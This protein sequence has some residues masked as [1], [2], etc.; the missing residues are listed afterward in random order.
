[1][2]KIITS[3]S[4]KEEIAE[5]FKSKFKISEQSCNSII[6]EDISGDILLSLSDKEF[7]TLDLKIGP[8][9]KITKYLS[10]NKAYFP[11]KEINENLDINSS[12][13]EVK[14]F[15][16]EFIGYTGDKKFDGKKLLEIDK[17]NMLKMGLNL[18]QR[19]RLEK[20]INYFK[21]TTKEK[22]VSKNEDRKEQKD[23]REETQSP[24]EIKNTEI[25]E[26]LNKNGKQKIDN[27]FSDPKK[28]EENKNNL[29]DKKEKKESYEQQ[30]S[31]E[32]EKSNENKEMNEKKEGK[33]NGKQIAYK[34]ENEA[35]ADKGEDKVQIKKEENKLI[36]KEE[37]EKKK[38]KEED[39]KLNEGQI[40][41]EKDNI[42]K[43]KEKIEVQIGKD[44]GKQLNKKEENEIKE[45]KEQDK[46]IT[47]K[48][49]KETKEQNEDKE[50][51][52]EK[53]NPN[54]NKK[55]EK[56][57]KENKEIKRE[58]EDEEVNGKKD[59]KEAKEINESKKKEGA[60]LDKDS[61][62]S[63]H[64]IAKESNKEK[65]KEQTFEIKE[66]IVKEEN[67]KKE[68]EKDKKESLESENKSNKQNKKKKKKQKQEKSI[69]SNL[70]PD[71]LKIK[72][73]EEDNESEEENDNKKLEQ[74]EKPPT[75]NYTNI[76]S[77]EVKPLDI[78]SKS[79][80]FFI[81]SLSEDYYLNSNLA[82]YEEDEKKKY[83]NYSHII[84]S[85]KKISS[86]DK[87]KKRIILVQV[88]LEKKI[89][90]LYIKFLLK[91][92]NINEN[93]NDKKEENKGKEENIDKEQ[94]KNKEENK[95]KEQNKE[96][97]QNKV[98]EQNKEDSKDNFLK[99]FKCQIEVNGEMN[100]YFYL[101]NLNFD[102]KEDIFFDEN[103]DYLLGEYYNYFFDKKNNDKEIYKKEL[104]QSLITFISSIKLRLFFSSNNLFKFFKLCILYEYKI[105]NINL[106]ELF[107][108]SD[109]YKHSIDEENILNGEE[110]DKLLLLFEGKELDIA[111]QKLSSIFVKLYSNFNRYKL[112]KD[113]INSKNG[114]IYMRN[115]FKLILQD[116]IKISDLDIK[117][118]R[119][120][121]TLKKG[122]LEVAKSKDEI[123]YINKFSKGL[124]GYLEFINENCNLICN[125]LE[126]NEKQKQSKEANYILNIPFPDKEDKI[127][128][129]YELLLVILKIT[130]NKKYSILKY[131]ELFNQLVDIAANESIDELCLLKKFI[132]PLKNYFKKDTIE[133]YYNRIHQKG[134][135]LIKNEELGIGEILNF[136]YNQDIYYYDD[137]YKDSEN[138]DPGIFSYTPIRNTEIDN[139][140]NIIYL[141]ERKIWEL[142]SKSQK[143]KIIKF[144]EVFLEQ[145][146][147]IKDLIPL[148]KLFP[149]SEI[150]L[151]F[152]NLINKKVVNILYTCLDED[153]KI[154]SNSKELF[155]IFEQLLIYNNQNNLDVIA[156]I[157]LVK[158]N[159]PYDFTSNYFFYLLQSKNVQ[160]IIPKIKNNII[161]YFIEQ[162]KL[163]NTTIDSLIFL[164]KVAPDDN[165]RIEL[166]NQM[167][168]FIM[169]ENDFYQKSENKKFIL[170]KLFNE[171]FP[172]LI[173]KN[174]NKNGKYLIET[175]NLKNK[176]FKD[177]NSG[178]VIYEII[179][180][181]LENENSFYNKIKVLT[182]FNDKEAKKLLDKIK[183]FV[184]QSQAK[185][186]I[187]DTI[188]DYYNTFYNESKREIIQIIKDNIKIVKQK[189]IKKVLDLDINKFV[190]NENFNLN[191]CKEDAENI[192]YKYSLFFMPIYREKYSNEHLEKTE[193][194]IFN[195]TIIILKDI[196][197]RI[198]NQK[199]T[200]EPFFEINYVEIILRIIQ[201]KNNNINNE[202]NFISQELKDLN[203]DDYIKNNLLADLINFSYKNSLVTLLQGILY[204]IDTFNKIKE[205]QTTDIYNNIQNIYN[206]VTQNNVTAD[207]IKESIDFLIKYGYNIK[208]EKTSLM[209]FYELLLD[210]EDAITFIKKIKE[211]QL[212]I[213]NLNEFIDEQD[214]SQ[215]TT[216]DIDNLLDIYNFINGI[217]ENQNITRDFELIE[218]FKK[219]FNE[220]KNIVIK[221]KEYLKCYGEIIQ[222]YKLY[223]ENPEVTT[224]KVNKIL[225]NSSVSFFKDEKTNLYTFK[226]IYSNQNNINKD[227]DISEL[228]EL[229]YR[230]YMSSTGTN[231]LTEENKGREDIVNKEAM[232]NKFVALIDNLN[233]LNKTLNRLIKSGYPFISN[234]SLKIENSETFD[235]KDKSKNLPK[236]IEEHKSE[237]KKF[238]KIIKRG[239]QTKPL[240]RLFYAYQFIQIYE[241]IILPISKKV[242]ENN[243]PII[244][245]SKYIMNL[246]NYMMQNQIY[247]FD[248]D[249][250]YK[251]DLDVIA[252]INNYLELLLKKNDLSL[253]KIYGSN[254]LLENIELTPGL[255]RK[256]KEGDYS[257]LSVDIINIYLN[258]TGNFPIV[259]T[260]L[261]C[262]EETTIEE[263]KAFLY[264]AIYCEKPILF[265][266]T[267][268]ECLG[269]S[270]TQNILKTIRKLYK[271]KNRNINSYLVFIYEKIDSGFSRF[272]EKLIPE[273]NILNKNFLKK[274]E[275]R[276]ENLDKTVVYSSI[277]SG[278]GK[279][280]EIYYHVKDKSG[281]YYYLPLGGTFTRD[282]VIK[283]LKNLKLDTQNC[284]YIY[285]HLDLSDT[286]KDEL[287]NEILFKLVILRYL[288][289]NEEIF[290]LGY[291]INII[292]EI[293]QGFFDFEKK[294]KILTLFKKEFIDKLRP[295]R[296][297]ENARFL[298]ES[299]ISIVAEVLTYYEEDKIGKR[300]IDLDDP[301][302]MSAEECELIINKYFNVE[303]Q[304]YY[305]KINFIKILSLQFKKLSTNF[306]LDYQMAFINGI[307][308]LIKKAR[309]SII[310]N[311][312][313]L[314]KVFTR[315][316][317]DQLLIK[318]Q[319]ESID[320]YNRYDQNLAIEK[321]ISA[322]ENEKQ[323][324]FSFDD[325]KPSL[326]FFNK[327]GQSFGII[328]N[329]DKNDEEYKELETLWNSN[330]PD[331]RRRIPLI[332]YKSMSHDK[333]LE[334]IQKVFSLDSFNIPKLKEICVKAGNYIFVCDN[335]IKMVRILLN[336]E[337]KIPVILMGE[338][339]V[340]KTKI[341]EMLAT[342]YGKGRL[343]WKKKEI[344][345][346]TTDEEIVAFIDKIIEEDKIENPD[347]DLT[348]VFFDEINTCNSLGLITEIM[349]KHTYLG[350]KISDNLV[351]LGACNPY[352]VLN[353]KMRESGL[354]YYNT[355]DKSK[356]NNLV[357]S[358][359]PLPHSLLNF[360]FDFGSLRKKDEEKY[361]HN[362]IVS[363]IDNIKNNDLI[364]NISDE[365]LGKLIEII[366]DSI[367][368]CHDFIREKYDRS[369]V[370]MREIRRFGIFF[371]YFIKYFSMGHFSDLKR[372]SLSLNMTIYLCYYLR[373]NDKM[374]R[375]ELAQKLNKYYPKSSF[376]SVPENEIKKITKEMVIE[377][378]KG[379]ALNRALREN[380][381]TCFTCIINNVPLII[382]GKPGTGKSLS[383]QILYNSMK[384]EYSESKLFKD[385]GKLYRYYYQGSETSTAEGITQVFMKALS[386]Q[387]NNKDKKIIPLVFFDEMGLAE[388]SSNNPL[389]VIHFL[390]EKDAKD[391]VPFLGISNW[392]LDAAK[393]NRALGLTITDYDIQ[394]LEE[395][396]IS[397]A[398]AMD[399]RLTSLY[400]DFFKTLA[401]TYNKYILQNQK[402]AKDNKDFHGNRDFYNLI[403]NAMRE[404]IA[405]RN[406][407]KH[408]ER[409]ILTEVGILSLERNFGGLEDSTKKVKEI[410]K[411]EF[412][413]KFDESVKID[414][415]IDIF[416]I[417][418]KNI[419]DQNSRYLML[420]S[421]GNDA[422][423]ILKCL[424]SNINKRYIE[425]VGSKY[426]LDIKSGRYSEEILN[427]IKYIMET[428]DILILKDLDMIYP[429][430][431]DLF[432][433]N[434]TIM[435]NK[436]FARIAFEYAKISSEVNRNFHVVVLVN[437]IQIQNLKLDPPFL[438]RFEK[439]IVS[440]RML[441]DDEDISIG[442]KIY[443]Y[444]KLIVTY[445][446]NKKL[447]LDLEKLL[448]NCKQHDIEGL[449]FK[450]KTDNPAILKD[451]GTKD[452]ENYI[453]NEIFKKI[454]P[455]F[456]QDII[457]SIKYSN[458]NIKYSQYNE[459]IY[460]IY[461]KTQ[462]SNFTSFF[463]NI[464][465]R[466]NI[467]YTF[468]K[469]TENIFEEKKIIE[470]KFGTYSKQSAIDE[471][472]DSFK[473]ENDL[474]FLLK[475][476]SNSQKLNILILRFGEND[477]N[478]LNSVNYL[479]NTY[480]KE[481]K[482]LQ[483]KQIMFI[484]H[485]KR[486]TILDQKSKN[487]AK[488]NKKLVIPDLIPF[489]NDEYY[490]IFID[491]LQGNEGMDLFKVISQQTEQLTQQYL[492]ESNLI[493]NKIYEV[494]NYINFEV[495]F[496][497]KEINNNNYINVIAKKIIDNI[498]IKELLKKNIEKQGKILGGVINE[499]YT[500]DILE[501]N[502]IDFFEV[503]NSKLSIYLS[504]CLL[505]VIFSG[506]KENLFNQIVI[507]DN[508]DLFMKNEY[509]KNLIKSY[510]DNVDFNFKIKT[511]VNLNKI[512]IYNGLQIP[513]S[514][515]YLDKIVKYVDDEI[516]NRFI[517]NED[518][519]RKN[520]ES[521]E[522]ISDLTTNYINEL[523]QFENNI[524]VE[525]NNYELFK[526]IYN[527]NN[528]EIKRKMRE[529]YLIYYVIKII[530]K[531]NTNYSI[532]ENILEILYLLLKIKFCERGALNRFD[533]VN[534]IEE[535]AKIILFTQGYKEDIIDIINI[536]L[537]IKN[538]CNI[539]KYM[540]D[541][542]EE[543]IIKYEDSERNQKYT[544]KVNY[545]F[546][547]I[548]ESLIRG[549]LLY[550]IELKKNDQFKFYEFFFTLPSIEANLQKINQKY[551]LYSKQIYNLSS[552]IKIHEC[553]KFNLEE[554]ENK[555]EE[556]VNNL[557]NQS[558]LLY[559]GSYENLYKKI[560][561]LHKIF[562]DTFKDKNNEFTNLLF[563]ITRQEYQ[564]INNESIKIKLIENIFENS[565][566]IKKSYTFL[567][568]TMKDLKPEIF[569]K[570]DKER[571]NEDIL[572]RN[573]LN[574]KDNR[575]LFKY[576]DLYKLF[577]SL[578]SPEFNELLLFF[579]ENQ[580]QSYF[581]NILNLYNNKFVENCC[582]ALLLNTS[583]DYLK[584]SL[585][586]IYEHKDN[587]DNNI[588]KMYSI[589]YIKTYFYYY[590]EI[591]YNHF[592]K[593]NYT[594]INLLLMDNN[595]NI[596]Y[597]INMRN[598]Y[599]FR[600][601]FKKFDNF[602][603][604]KNF[605]FDTRNMPLYKNLAETIKL[606]EKD[607]DNYIF[608]D[609][610][611]NL[612]NFDKYKNFIQII[613]LFLL[614][615]NSKSVDFNFNEVN[616]NF[617]VFFCCLV[618]KMISYLYGNNKNLIEEKMKYLYESTKD[619]IYMGEEGKILYQYLFNTN[620]LENN[621]FKKI[622]DDKLNQEDFEILLYVLRIIFNTQMNKSNNFYNNILKANTCKFIAD[623]YIP[624]SFPYMNEYIKSYNFLLT[625]FPPKELMGYYICKDCG[626]V[627]EIRPC[628]FPVHTYQCPNGHTIGGTNHILSKKDLRIFYD[629][630]DLNGFC[631]GR[632]QSYI[633]SFNGMTLA[634]FKKNYVDKHL[635][636]KEKGILENFE[637]DDFKKNDPVRELNNLTYRFLNLI[638]YS[639]LL[640]SYILQNLSIE[641]MRK[642]LVDNLFP[643][644]LFG[645]IK[646]DWEI[647]NAAL[648]EIGFENINI[649]MNTKFNE[650]LNL[651]NNLETVD[652]SEK[653]DKFEKSVDK[654]I[655]DI[656]NNKDNNEQLNNEYKQLN[657]KLLNFNPQSIKEIIQS[658]Y[659]PSIY[660][661]VTYP[662]IQ[663]Y[664]VSKIIN[665]ETFIEKFNSSEENKNKYA[666][667]NIL[668][669][670][671]SELTKNA[672]NMKSLFAINKLV[673]LLL[674]IYSYKI[675]RE[676]SKLK[677]LDEEIPNIIS[678]YN[679]MNTIKINDNESFISEYISPFIQSWNEIKS[680]SVQYKCRVLRDLEKGEKPYEM[681][682]DNLL[683]DFLVDD[684]DKEGGMFLAAA[685][686]YLIESQ[687]TFIDNIISKN[688]IKGILNSYVSQ[689]EQK[690][691]IQDASK[692]EI[693]NIDDN[694]Y[695]LLETLVT[696]NSLRNIFDDKKNEIDYSNYNDIIYNYD[697]IEE[698]LGKKIL[699]GLKKFNN[700][701][702]RF[703]TFL[704][705]GFRGEHSS[706][707]VNYNNKYLQRDLKENEKEALND[708]LETNNSSKFYNDVFSSLQIL[709]NQII[710]E[711]YSQNHLLYSI[712][713]NLPSY[714]ILNSKLVDFFKK[715]Y[716]YYSELQIFTVNS[717][718]SIFEYFESLCWK[719]M[720]KNI[721][722]DY[723]QEL[724]E[725]EKNDFISYFE[726]NNKEEKVINKE[727]FTSALR[728][729]ICRS[730]SGSRQE[731][732]IK[733]DGKLLYYI[734]RE[735]LWNK[736][737][738]EKEE[739]DNEVYEIFKNEILVSQAVNLY[740]VL[741]GDNILQDKLFKNKEKE[742]EN[743][744]Q[745]ENIAYIKD[746]KEEGDNIINTDSS[747]MKNED[748]NEEN[749]EKED[750][751]ASQKS[752]R[753][754]D[755]DSEEDDE[756][757]DE[758][759]ERVDEI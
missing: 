470:N 500:S 105:K 178:Q 24:I 310:K 739:F 475:S 742:K 579:F 756:D 287:M 37:K 35:Q 79:N 693:I 698:E 753:D 578:N 255:Y 155:E 520:Y 324:I 387:S 175:I 154:K 129:I 473:C 565:L 436:Q 206:K 332:D 741:E 63:S 661:Q 28:K 710:K 509:F 122:F 339:G 668:I 92:E 623:N 627:Y 373:L 115:I 32:K 385:K 521:Q 523:K 146:M 441:L 584:K 457:A 352:R 671:D 236:I 708:L 420:I 598:I 744:K 477:L 384:G 262:N 64:D 238:K 214:N 701:K 231:L 285:L 712:I 240:L 488:K 580:C 223:D 612:N 426:K 432:N 570:N 201:N 380:L 42:L 83:I 648:K 95:D 430:L 636:H 294:Y 265:V 704:Y 425:L 57:I 658:N 202:I 365:D 156:S 412:K 422:G 224:Q 326:V 9:K 108:E 395:T 427:K 157:D 438:N 667:I 534:D 50:Q 170:F 216:T 282:Y 248:I 568:D 7:K 511:G 392:K 496:E 227:I 325:I 639:Y 279:T 147:D 591:N 291:D 725:N 556:I 442:Q 465:Q 274:P 757:S 654:F 613:N 54:E 137:T 65:A 21:S 215:L 13:E 402:E 203:K 121:K 524:L 383:F 494:L 672:K 261:F 705:E 4:S 592:D 244:E 360:V 8:I 596:K 599:I 567:V 601:Y 685:Y 455:T 23:N 263:I 94:N 533:F 283:N 162:H 583:L 318:R 734:T 252:N 128:K 616:E 604:F 161:N 78:N 564:N 447:K 449:I 729:L 727:N 163:G 49:N 594:D 125:I 302:S 347:K 541:I 213:R 707:L 3:N 60:N 669:N 650:I 97:E 188:I 531:K 382:V 519:L 270:V 423:E 173:K 225:K 196:F 327:D 101:E 320:I 141:K 516:C 605:P 342:L 525:I 478:K 179:E 343:N 45:D 394:D 288:D 195:S 536:I 461:K 159:L 217:M 716:E 440:F 303:N 29:E 328:S 336:I 566:L 48:K 177:L 243:S 112:L 719:E 747:K 253:D 300:N 289:S 218:A 292:I 172:D 19:K 665:M 593:C 548:I 732:E 398:E 239:Y 82:T 535:F 290:Y 416:D 694:I 718:V 276:H 401:R 381:F 745:I 313:A 38:D 322:L 527:Q 180:N 649:F 514:K 522:E 638:L 143:N 493:D 502:D 61:N 464:Q 103:N 272:L 62:E 304:N 666:L 245:P 362:T 136:I 75:I 257:D 191:Q 309:I 307:G 503:I 576:K 546:F 409:T 393:I 607:N 486:E 242:D 711:N 450:I 460:N 413:H 106:I 651:I 510:F 467:V 677:K 549:I 364:K 355:K 59:P 250:K 695:D 553:Y 15:L 726:K 176:I 550:S 573:F 653:L 185:F 515:T 142:F 12:A 356:L 508:Y 27:E 219:T 407:I 126:K 645:I 714:I 490:Q 133:K 330:N 132:E 501:V 256:I 160:K 643:H 670:K 145:I 484:I 149:S 321:A 499:I 642:Y 181:L 286:D 259:N 586:Y 89:K 689:L 30:G 680:K 456:C 131:D 663:Y 418:K 690:I 746:K 167:D 378:N 471:M 36:N 406:N 717:L 84:L 547:K 361:I 70:I 134:M 445:N 472:I 532:N 301:I 22:K 628:T 135:N 619:K 575:K 590:V 40:D 151:D 317:Y 371:E 338:T 346:G 491:N 228:N 631:N 749:I 5:F 306:Y 626:Y 641:E 574:I 684:G 39:K 664:N 397:I 166:L 469:I 299:P 448:I 73:D 246:I 386:S 720:K 686:Q 150:N 674:A 375:R 620:L 545:Y 198:I 247:D 99:E 526:E 164:I 266:I 44:K 55:E 273:K 232:T 405:R 120:M 700:D 482:K 335:F 577:N 539:G 481:N 506:L 676:D 235:E 211:S 629:Q 479:I 208:E 588:L 730:I 96:K 498:Q 608:K 414:R 652:T 357:Y 743:Q 100:N 634:D 267:N 367:V 369:S 513:K 124:I 489:I 691:N 487:K 518:S 431:Y 544:K 183:D 443:D 230:I 119:E 562:D 673:N 625:K 331:T 415:K 722:P 6:K 264:R 633:N 675:S 713:E 193:D 184:K 589:A 314:T 428:D 617:D 561:D 463:R 569:D 297:E 233:Q 682:I 182:D 16:K 476:F 454:V 485:K 14:N 687:N 603:Q 190:E 31:N 581:K 618:N 144:Y 20:Y 293:P 17:E 353:K 268:L 505:K 466:R 340:G 458:M 659:P 171:K 552:I 10:E 80:I 88:P 226:I 123:N 194:D 77:N 630:N 507:S 754:N 610:F 459:L 204:F 351:F 148:F 358:V 606:E 737:V 186:D 417:I 51:D 703:V 209:E 207:E 86:F 93:N 740:N 602:E 537:D 98:K 391:S 692:S 697:Y 197:T 333:Y 624:G 723:E 370:S 738:M 229:R 199:S 656:I 504:T 41:K 731:I 222:L 755:V 538:Y 158:S 165:F 748:N 429:S 647:L 26:Y 403:K 758:E 622:S 350:K 71:F 354:V 278:Y 721:G 400:D 446:N 559:E 72:S 280:T 396:A 169:E 688:N 655:I 269:L 249:F 311:F 404:L 512:T 241:Q 497:T 609:S 192:K 212:E 56:E 374:Y 660:S 210:K 25:K 81:L 751:L 66:K 118:K 113:L 640:G 390:L 495:Q 555:Y 543:N 644:S 542:L 681:K 91:N 312:I 735:D 281:D 87:D 114:K 600:V 715:Q 200:K 551:N 379:I 585:Q 530:E 260:L 433:Q 439:H 34:E 480:Q 557:L 424:L 174:K 337:A 517:D 258:L 254:K 316:P 389:K 388:R 483:N 67:V 696:T 554:F 107:V 323:E 237:S 234:F 349:C 329:A 168:N 359:N 376:L 221:M 348:W 220:K 699:P 111:Q 308:D 344:H 421:D 46:Q 130:K 76:N 474:L 68:Q 138:R 582:K 702:I 52:K 104:I 18:G 368:I 646:K 571:N 345:A 678:I 334:E 683:C 451:K 736:N 69:F 189:N 435:G 74:K 85:N 187:F 621:I 363:I 750:T 298:R 205:I 251:K 2:D 759:E 271:A 410:F 43:N 492:K 728:K 724:S 752:Y 563:F 53:N 597:I 635:L 706:A 153:G 452:Y 560:M 305:Q 437:N 637:I 444:I 529:D 453:I 366:S 372:M 284:T 90:K 127:E 411:D 709:M 116:E 319:T 572:L 109:Q 632:N 11:E 341:L 558:I 140:S 102:K 117:D 462:Y 296:L 275:K 315:S 295:L 615:N 679:E 434:F 468:S 733:P 595:E 419:L 657:N 408:N 1:M 587:N 110:V 139:S 33:E 377:K 47:N 540:T 277:F 152:I 528:E 58:N 399:D 614:D 662:D 611:L